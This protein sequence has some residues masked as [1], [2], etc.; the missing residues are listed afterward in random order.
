MQ[1][2]T[3]SCQRNI[4]I[5]STEKNILATL[6]YF[7]MFSYPLKKREIFI[8]LP[9]KCEFNEFEIAL[10][11]LIKESSIFR[12]G[13]FYSL[14]NNYALAEIRCDGNDR[15]TKMLKKA[16]RSAAI[17]SLFPFVKGIAIS[18]SLSKKY[19]DINSDIDFFIIAAA[20]RLWIAR[21]CL[22]VFKKF[23]YLFQLQHHYCMNYFIDEAGLGILER[24]IYTATEVSTI[25]PLYGIDI[26]EAFYS[27]NNWTRAFLP[28]NYLHI[29]SAQEIKNHQL[30]SVLEKLLDNRIGNLLDNFLMRLTAKSWSIKSQRKA[31][32]SKGFLMGL[33]TGKHFAKPDPS[34][35]QKRL[36]LRYENSLAEILDRHARVTPVQNKSL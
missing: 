34:N 2:P 7:D 16:E 4:I 27:V 10:I 18:G 21:T 24:N 15:A 17:I 8:F 26:F 9:V 3:L 23:T 22:H 29:S 19:A 25:L 20:N 32:N 11:S 6:A 5:L 35:F 31:K 30:K 36:L 1:Y 33:H 14:R 13:E 12:V 28:N